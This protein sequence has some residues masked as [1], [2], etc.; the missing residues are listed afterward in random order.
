[1]HSLARRGLGLVVL[2]VTC[3]PVA[4]A[5]PA[6]AASPKRGATYTGTVGGVNAHRITFKVSSD[7]RRVTNVRATVYQTCQGEPGRINTFVPGRSFPIR[8]G[9][10]SGE[11]SSPRWIFKGAFRRNGTASGTLLMSGGAITEPSAHASVFCT[12]FEKT[13]T[14]RAR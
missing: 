7:G 6:L 4:L 8:G 3:F 5:P 10:F 1:M 14:A 2:L 9:R 12:T 11:S 13:W